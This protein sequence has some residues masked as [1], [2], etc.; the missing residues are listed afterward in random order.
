[1][2]I[3]HVRRISSVLK[4]IYQGKI[5]LSDIKDENSKDDAFLT[6]SQAAYIIS[7]LADIDH[8]LSAKSIVDGFQDNGIDAIFFNR[9][10]NTFYLVQSKWVSNG[11]KSPDL[12]S[13]HKFLNGIK[14]I[15]H[16]KFEKFNDKV[17]GKKNEMLEALDSIYV[18]FVIVIVYTGTQPLSKHASDLLDEFVVN[19][20]QS[21]EFMYLKVYDQQSL[22]K[23]ITGGLLGDPINLEVI[24]HNWG[25]IKDPYQAVYGYV[26]AADIAQWYH[27]YDSRLLAKNLR[28]YK[29]ETDVNSAIKKTIVSD[30]ENFWYFNNGITV[31][32]NSISKTARGGTDR[33]VGIYICNGVSVVNG[34]QTVGTIA[35]THTQ[36]FKGTKDAKVFVRFISLENCP[37]GFGAR[38]TT[39]TNTQNQ[40]FQRDFASLDPNQER[41]KSELWYDLSKTY[42]YRGE[43]NVYPDKGCTIEEAA[44]GLACSYGDVTLAVHAKREVSKLFEDIKRAPYTLLFNADLTAVR[45]WN[46][47]QVSRAVESFLLQEK[48]N[49][50]GTKRLIAVHGNRYILYKVFQVFSARD[51]EE[52]NFDLPSFRQKAVSKA[53]K[54]VEQI[55]EAVSLHFN[56]VYLNGLFKSAS[57]CGELDL[58]LPKDPEMIPRF[59]NQEEE[60]QLS[61]F[62]ED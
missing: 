50:S 33:S 39:A 20:N 43:T 48:H 59:R 12:G 6:R 42:L 17:L 7:H 26:N 37:P 21:G 24:L 29:G 45:M 4:E 58:L 56:G 5:D 18:R 3:I 25:E 41:L 31:L 9:S 8:E 22:V 2:A 44:I 35:E 36:G 23:A 53:Q 49:L 30:P 46:T 55:A 16:A 57:Q 1:M 28:T 27:E 60:L 61:L 51:F 38:V 34:A 54:Y 47:V 52:P 11:V 19:Q 10:T 14:D 40:I 32:C 15:L 13:I 62:K